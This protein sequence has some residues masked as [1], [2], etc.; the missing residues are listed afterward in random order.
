[1]QHEYLGYCANA[2]QRA[3][4]LAPTNYHIYTSRNASRLLTYSTINPPTSNFRSSSASQTLLDHLFSRKPLTLEVLSPREIPNPFLSRTPYPLAT[5]L[6]NALFPFVFCM[7]GNEVLQRL[8]R[9]QESRLTTALR[10]WLMTPE[11]LMVTHPRVQS[12]PEFASA[13]LFNL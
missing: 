9:P 5:V 12:T 10:P 4:S 13:K 6:V 3:R 7:S 11:S 2:L 1:M 8:P